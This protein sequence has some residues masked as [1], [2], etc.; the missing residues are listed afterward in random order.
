VP[1]PIDVAPT[2]A[3]YETL[4]SHL[5]A[6]EVDT[7]FEDAAALEQAATRAAADASEPDRT[8]LASLATAATRLKETPADD[9]D[10]ARRSFGETSRHLIAFF[11]TRPEAR[12]GLSTYE[13]DRALGF[14]RW[15]QPAG[16]MG[17]PYADEACGVI[18]R[19]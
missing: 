13:C 14:S 2:L 1:A 4:R 17:C 18:V 9:L 5:A 15:V 8:H 16:P 12:E 10:E 7:L 3:A 11:R 6:G 19:D